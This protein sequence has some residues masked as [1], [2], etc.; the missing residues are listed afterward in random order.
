MSGRWVV[1]VT[2]SHPSSMLPDHN[3]NS[4]KFPIL[5]TIRLPTVSYQMVSPLRSS[6]M[7]SS[8]QST[9]DLNM[10]AITG[11]QNQ[12]TGASKDEFSNRKSN[13]RVLLIQLRVLDT[14]CGD[15]VRWRSRRD[16]NPQPLASKANDP[17]IELPDPRL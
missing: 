6:T 4:T 5:S 13:L 8:T 16:S 17:S 14:E 11:G 15:K 2:R 10:V 12:L 7:F 1:W 9:T 3:T